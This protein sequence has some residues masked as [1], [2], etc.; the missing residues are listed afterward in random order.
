MKITSFSQKST[1]AYTTSYS[2]NFHLVDV[3]DKKFIFEI[4]SVLW[5]MK[6]QIIKVLKKHELVG[7]AIKDIQIVSLV[8]DKNKNIVSYS[9]NYIELNYFLRRLYVL[10]K[11]DKE[12]TEVFYHLEK[13]L[14]E[15]FIKL[16]KSVP[17]RY[18]CNLNYLEE[19]DSTASFL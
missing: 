7:S 1:Y 6:D 18:S 2:L 14:S 3:N 13:D 11:N 5:Q 19:L 4:N 12:L 8:K 15:S 9:K 16:I 17:K 10:E